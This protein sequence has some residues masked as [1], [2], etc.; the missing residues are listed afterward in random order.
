MLP[1]T[2]SKRAR[3]KYAKMKRVEE[4]WVCF[5]PIITILLAG[6]IAYW[7]IYFVG[8]YF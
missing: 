3:A 8:K 5:M 4:L 7:G 2:Y 6:N 1:K